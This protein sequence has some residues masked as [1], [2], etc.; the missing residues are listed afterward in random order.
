MRQPATD[1]ALRPARPA[2][3]EAVGALLAASYP[4]LLAPAYSADVLARALPAMIR[5]SPALLGCGTWYL[6]HAPDGELVGCGGWTLAPPGA[7][8]GLVDPRRA[9]VRHF[10]THPAWVRRGVGRAL[11]ARSIAIARCAGVRRLDCDASLVAR[12]FYAAQGFVAVRPITVA[13]G[14][15]G[16]AAIRMVRDL[17]R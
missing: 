10:A 3:A 6:A 8:S 17:A 1:F 13:I 16:F 4:A 12:P 2:D 9:H 15:V 5:A 14:G 7:R 11:L